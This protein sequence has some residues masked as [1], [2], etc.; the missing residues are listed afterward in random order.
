MSRLN[1]VQSTTGLNYDGSGSVV[2]HG[3]DG[4][5]GPHIDY[6][7][8]S[9]T[10]AREQ[11]RAIMETMWRERSLVGVFT[12]PMEWGWHPVPIWSIRPISEFHFCRSGLCELQRPDHHFLLFE[13][14][15]RGLHKH[16]A[17]GGQ[18]HSAEPAHA[19]LFSRQLSYFRLR[20]WCRKWMGKHHRWTQ[21]RKECHRLGEHDLLRCDLQLLES[22]ARL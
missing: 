22:R 9:Y 8:E 2:G 12:I 15:Q 17:A 19:R 7:A 20:L 6:A 4:D 5:I 16:N 3:D 1:K 21:G 11:A 10:T 13:W 14:V 18:R